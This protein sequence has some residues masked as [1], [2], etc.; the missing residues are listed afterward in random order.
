M[1]AKDLQSLI[2]N[3]KAKLARQEAIATETKGQIAELEKL[4]K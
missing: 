1:A 2:D 4:L 3:L